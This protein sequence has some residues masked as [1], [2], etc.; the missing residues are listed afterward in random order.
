MNGGQIW[1]R[2]G[3]GDISDSMNEEEASENNGGRYIAGDTEG[4]Q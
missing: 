2:L 3:D 4:L 1:N